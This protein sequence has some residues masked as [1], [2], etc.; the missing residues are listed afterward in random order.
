MQLEAEHGCVSALVHLSRAHV[1]TVGLSSS[2]QQLVQMFLPIKPARMNGQ[3]SHIA[4]PSQ[5]HRALKAPAKSLLHS[6]TGNL[7]GQLSCMHD[8]SDAEDPVSSRS[9]ALL[10][11]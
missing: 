4:V 3:Q 5:Q 6:S 2:L 11:Q 9:A 10:S 7:L 8:V 1:Y